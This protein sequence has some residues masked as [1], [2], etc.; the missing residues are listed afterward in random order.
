MI[1]GLFLLVA[2]LSAYGFL[3]IPVAGN[4]LMVHDSAQPG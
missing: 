2:L 4:S 1:A 3:K